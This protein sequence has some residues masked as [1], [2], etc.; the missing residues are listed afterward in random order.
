[1]YARTKK[2]KFMSLPQWID[3]GL[4]FSC[5]GCGK[6]CTGAPGYIWVNEEEIEAIALHLEMERELFLE[7]YT[8]R[9]GDRVSLLDLPERNHDCVFLNGKL[10][11]IYEV[12]PTQCRT[13]P[14]WPGN[15]RT[16]EAW[17]R[18]AAECE[19][20]SSNAAL[21][22]PATILERIRETEEK[23]DLTE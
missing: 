3:N 7:R 14:F 18:E 12:R 13:Y 20:I 19:G 2:V 9:V 1:M 16:K 8:E 11:E 4:K 15:I 5:T 22:E 21:V 17:L 23:S 6:C 10:C